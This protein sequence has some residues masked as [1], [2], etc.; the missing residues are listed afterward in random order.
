MVF[1]IGFLATVLSFLL[2]NRMYQL[3]LPNADTYGLF[4]NNIFASFVQIFTAVFYTIFHP[5]GWLFLYI[6]YLLSML[7]LKNITKTT[8]KTKTIAFYMTLIILP[9]I[10]I[11]IS[12][13]L[14]YCY[15]HIFP[16]VGNIN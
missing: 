4:G 9:I 15:T 5:I 6:Y 16:F 3:G 10:G 11:L 7:F 8:N 2:Y 14:F 13:L 1:L 12:G